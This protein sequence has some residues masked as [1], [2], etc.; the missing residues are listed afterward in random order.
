MQRQRQELRRVK[1]LLLG[2]GESGKST[3]FKQMNMLY[4]KGYSESDRRGFAPVIHTN[5]LIA[6][7]MLAANAL[8]YGPL[9]PAA[10]QARI[11][12][13]NVKGQR[14][15]TELA[16]MIEV[17]WKDP[18]IRIAFEHRQQFQLFD[19]ANHF[20]NQIG[21]LT[22]ED[23]LPSFED[24][25]LIRARTTGVSKNEFTIDGVVFQM[26]DVGGQRNERKKWISI[27][28]NVTAV[29]FVAAISEYDQLCFEDEKTNRMTEALNL[30]DEICNSP[31]FE[32]TSMI[33][34]LNKRDLFSTK[35]QT[36]PLKVCF[37]EYPGQNNFEEGTT[38]VRAKFLEK[39]TRKEKVIYTHITC[40]TDQNNVRTVFLAV[41]DIIIRNSLAQAGLM[42]AYA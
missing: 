31:Y 18:T 27:F 4:G 35:I 5:V 12:V 19:S 28:D 23:Y 6:V 16:K 10:E 24:I 11:F 8:N 20:F 30:F 32:R 13:E 39:N 36:V 15:T 34:F 29:V 40:A 25:L 38:Y 3:L 17:L 21:N 26:F 37:P 2:A 22:K 9:S 33:L 7:Q 42:D 14:I 1:L 41:K